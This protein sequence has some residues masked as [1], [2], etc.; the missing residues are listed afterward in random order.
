MDRTQQWGDECGRELKD[1]IQ[2]Q[3]QG[4]D[5][6]QREDLTEVSWSRPIAIWQGTEQ[7]KG[8]T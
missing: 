2:D 3:L 7:V 6:M 1:G 4:S 8:T 5:D